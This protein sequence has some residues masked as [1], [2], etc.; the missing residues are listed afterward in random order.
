MCIYTLVLEKHE[1]YPFILFFIRDEEY[2]RPSLPL[3]VEEQGLVC[4]R[5]GG[6]GTWCGLNAS[7]GI[8]AALTGVRYA[9]SRRRTARFGRGDLVLAALL[10]PSSSS[11]SLQ[12]EGGEAAAEAGAGAA[13]PRQGEE[14]GTVCV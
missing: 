12:G 14:E 6:Y 4:A 13:A 3:A 2:D 5:D 1:D 9:W 11:S 7:R 8:V 10:S